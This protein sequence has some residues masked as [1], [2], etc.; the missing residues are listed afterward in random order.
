MQNIMVQFCSSSNTVDN[1][2]KQIRNERREQI[3][4]AAL[5]VFARKGLAATKISD[6]AVAAQLSHGLI[7][8]YFKSKDEIFTVLAT[9]ALETS[10][11]IIIYAANLP[12]TPW[13]RLKAMTESIVPTAYQGIGPYYFLIVIQAFTSEAVPT[14]VKELAARQFSVYTEHLVT[15]IREGQQ[16]GE[17]VEGDPLQLAVSYTSMIQGLVIMKTLGGEGLQLPTPGMVLRLLKA[18]TK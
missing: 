2:N 11:N 15:L 3:L 12:G 8:H 18:S 9:E 14:Q 7:Y 5:Q 1:A 16:V 13:E 6:I 10:T 4:Q 17:V